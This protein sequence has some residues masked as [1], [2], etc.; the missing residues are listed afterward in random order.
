MKKKARE[1]FDSWNY[2]LQTGDSGEV[3]KLY[4]NESTFL[5][6]LSGVFEKG[7]SGAENYFQHFLEKN[8]VGRIVSDEVQGDEDL[9]I[10]SGLYTFEVDGQNSDRVD[11]RA[12]FTF[13]YQKQKNGGYKILHHHSS[14]KPIRL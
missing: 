9:I 11:I 13:V 12:R 8:P 6:T 1:M 2:A 7:V 5:P 3:A 4:V 14:L 10:H